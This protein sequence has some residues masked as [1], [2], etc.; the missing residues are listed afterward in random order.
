MTFSTSRCYRLVLNNLRGS[1]ISNRYYSHVTKMLLVLTC[2]TNA[3]F[4]CSAG[5][6]GHRYLRGCHTDASEHPLWYRLVFPT[7]TKVFSWFLPNP[8]LFNLFITVYIFFQNCYAYP[9]SI[10]LYVHWSCS[11]LNNI[12][13]LFKVK[14]NHII[15]L[16]SYNNIFTN[17]Q[18]TRNHIYKYLQI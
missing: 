14:G 10:V 11:N 9:S 3:H 18:T 13:K 17:I 5:A 4:S 12:W 7:G 16:F 6:E 2:W 15:K 1:E 8:V